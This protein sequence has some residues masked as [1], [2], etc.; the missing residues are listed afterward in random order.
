M[1]EYITLECTECGQRNYRTQRETRGGGRMEI[2]KYC[3]RDR[4][5][6]AHKERRK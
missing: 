5:H 6:T 3:P 1:R 4:K 2:K